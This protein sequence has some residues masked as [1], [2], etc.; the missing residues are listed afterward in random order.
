[1][2]LTAKSGYWTIANAHTIACFVTIATLPC[3]LVSV[4][5]FQWGTVGFV[6][7]KISHC[8]FIV[9]YYFVFGCFL[10][11]T[12]IHIILTCAVLCCHSNVWYRAAL[13]VLHPVRK[14][15][16][17]WKRCMDVDVWGWDAYFSLPLFALSTSC[18]PPHH[19]SVSFG[20]GGGASSQ[21]EAMLVHRQIAQHAVVEE[22][23]CASNHAHMQFRRQVTSL[24][25]CTEAC[26]L[27]RYL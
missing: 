12:S 14:R 3:R 19:P 9:A 7:F 16:G 13:F 25:T 5:A 4:T 26:F 6:E 21:Q 11:F 1:M 18:W 10:L 8:Y 22:Q 15:R 24:H 20:K 27:C 2:T 17:G 23:L